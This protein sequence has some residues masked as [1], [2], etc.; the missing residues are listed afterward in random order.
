MKKNNTDFSSD[1][2]RS[3]L[4]RL[5]SFPM[6]RNHHII[7]SVAEQVSGSNLKC[8]PFNC[9]KLG[10][11]SFPWMR[12]VSSRQL[13]WWISSDDSIWERRT[14]VCCFTHNQELQFNFDCE[15][16][17][18]AL[19]KCPPTPKMSHVRQLCNDSSQSIIYN[20]LTTDVIIPYNECLVIQPFVTRTKSL[21]VFRNIYSSIF[22]LQ[23]NVSQECYKCHQR[24]GQ[25]KINGRRHFYCFTGMLLQLVYW[26]I[27]NSFSCETYFNDVF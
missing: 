22:F 15:T 19:L 3:W 6:A 11:I 8:P 20:N 13:Q 2:T 21:V 7:F 17:V 5:R 27:H 10:R 24:G 25:C 9:G 16:N 14:L 18:P 4:E 12:I 1:Q 23:V 26:L